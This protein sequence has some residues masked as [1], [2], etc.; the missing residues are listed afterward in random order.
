MKMMFIHVF[1]TDMKY[2]KVRTFDQ[3]NK[4]SNQYSL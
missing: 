1:H 2:V 4:D 3:I